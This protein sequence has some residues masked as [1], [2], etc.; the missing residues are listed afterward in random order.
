[1]KHG[2]VQPAGRCGNTA[3]SDEPRASTKAIQGLRRRSLR[4]PSSGLLTTLA[5]NSPPR[6]APACRVSK[7]CAFCRKSEPR[8]AMPEPEKSRKL[9]KRLHAKKIA[10]SAGVG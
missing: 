9:K 3:T 10:Q 7:P 1:M 4:P 8:L 5:R 6:A 2:N